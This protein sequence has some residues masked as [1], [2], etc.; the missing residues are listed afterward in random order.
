MVDETKFMNELEAAAQIKPSLFS[1]VLLFTVAAL[2]IIFILWASFSKIDERSRGQGQVVPSQEVQIVQSL[3]G[4]ILSELLV[5]EGDRVTKG[6]ILLRI[7]DVLFASE[8]RG[9]ESKSLSLQAK[10]AR[11]EAEANNTEFKLTDDIQNK[12]PAIANNERALYISRQEELENAISILDEKI[13]SA[14]AEI[15]ETQA[16]IKRIKNSRGHLY[17]ELKITEEMVKQKAIPKLEEI[18]LRREIDDLSGQLKVNEEKL[19]GVKAELNAAKKEKED[20]HDKFRSQALGELSEV[21]TQI[22]QLQESLK[23]AED[24]VYRA[25]LRAPVDGIVNSVSIKT[26][27]GVIEPAKK[28]IEIVPVDDELK[29]IAK[30]SPNDIAFLKLGQNAKVKIT[31]YDPQKYGSLDGKLTRIGANSVKDHE[32][33]IFFEVEVRTEKNYLGSDTNKLPITPGMLAEVD[34][35]TGKRTIMDYLLKPIFKAKD[36]ALSER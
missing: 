26:I 31:A 33:R 12:V 18:R 4:G 22:A 13:A 36:R 17:S 27:G 11:L 3:E 25:E 5:Q 14:D 35:I 7:S 9:L 28:L 20:Q 1:N 15:K 24:R 8:E 16:D 10:K 19:V 32:G 2:F 30:V 23:S 29:I 6:D 34:V 21:E